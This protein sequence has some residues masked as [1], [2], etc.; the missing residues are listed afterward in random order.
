MLSEQ[1]RSTRGPCFCF[2]GLVAKQTHACEF[3]SMQQLAQ[4][5]NYVLQNTQ[6]LELQSNE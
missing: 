5:L 1:A 6:Q 2:A 3:R 4:P